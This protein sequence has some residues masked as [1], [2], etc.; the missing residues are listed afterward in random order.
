MTYTVVT[1]RTAARTIARASAALHR[2]SDTETKLAVVLTFAAELAGDV[3]GLG[4]L[5]DLAVHVH[6]LDVGAVQN[7]MVAGVGRS[8]RR[9]GDAGTGMPALA[10]AAYHGLAG[11]IVRTIEPHTEADPV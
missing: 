1:L 7:A 5:S 10:A 2:A 4:E 9:N 6:G 8:P 11:E 3:D